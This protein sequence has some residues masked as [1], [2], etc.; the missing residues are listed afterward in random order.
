[1][2]DAAKENQAPADEMDPVEGQEEGNF[3]TT[4]DSTLGKYHLILLELARLA[5]KAFILLALSI[6]KLPLLAF[7]SEGASKKCAHSSISGI[8]LFFIS[9]AWTRK[10]IYI[11]LVILVIEICVF[12]ESYSSCVEEAEKVGETKKQSG[13]VIAEKKQEDPKLA[14]KPILQENKPEDNLPLPV[15]DTNKADGKIFLFFFFRPGK[16]Y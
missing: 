10:Y 16:L 14:S 8:S 9:C 7:M 4:D 1:L 2:E 5:S 12:V 6:L 3:I 11:F 15:N 13:K